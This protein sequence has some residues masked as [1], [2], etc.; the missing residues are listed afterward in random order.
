M[1]TEKFK[2]AAREFLGHENFAIAM[3]DNTTV[4]MPTG[5]DPLSSV[6]LDQIRAA[7]DAL[8]DPPPTEED[9]RAEAARRL[10][11]VFGATDRAE[12]ERMIR[13]AAQEA[14][15]LL[16]IRLDAGSWTAE[17]QTRADELRDGRAMIN[18][19]DAASKA[20]RGMAEIPAD[21]ADDS[22]WPPLPAP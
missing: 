6:D 1:D 14:V 11:I 22:H 13:D 16:D 10:A 12:L 7:A 21:Y 3:G 4:I 18:A 17:Q 15:E 8:P 5:V 9:V 20:L 2:Q 19:H